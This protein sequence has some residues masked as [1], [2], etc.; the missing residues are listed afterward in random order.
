MNSSSMV[1]LYR[2]Q[3]LHRCVTASNPD[4]SIQLGLKAPS[5]SPQ[6][7]E[8]L[9]KYRA[10]HG[11]SRFNGMYQV[12]LDPKSVTTARHITVHPLQPC[13]HIITHHVESF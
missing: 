1:G 13:Q 5:L 10:F 12:F 4:N 2:L 11:W 9:H 7:S 6:N 8:S 3:P